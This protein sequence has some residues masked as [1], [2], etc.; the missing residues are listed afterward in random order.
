MIVKRIT[1]TIIGSATAALLFLGT[2]VASGPQ[3][4]QGPWLPCPNNSIV[5]ASQLGPDL[6][7]TDEDFDCLTHNGTAG[8]ALQNGNNARAHCWPA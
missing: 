1:A 4:G 8:V 7:P 2:V 3:P 5:C 6:D